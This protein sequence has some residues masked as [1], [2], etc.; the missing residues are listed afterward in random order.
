MTKQDYAVRA[1]RTETKF[2]SRDNLM[3]QLDV[4]VPADALEF[5]RAAHN[6]QDSKDVTFTVQVVNTKDGDYRTLKFTSKGSKMKDFVPVATL[7]KWCDAH[8]NLTA[9]FDRAAYELNLIV[10]VR[11]RKPDAEPLF[12]DDDQTT[13]PTPPE[14]V[15]AGVLNAPKE[16]LALPAGEDIQDAEFT[17]AP[18]EAEETPEQFVAR[19]NQAQLATLMESAGFDVTDWDDPKRDQEQDAAEWRELLLKNWVRVEGTGGWAMVKDQFAN[20]LPEIDPFEGEDV[21]FG[22]AQPVAPVTT[23][24]EAAEVMDMLEACS[25]DQLNRLLKAADVSVALM[26]AKVPSPAAQNMARIKLLKNWHKVEGTDAL[27]QVK[28]EL[29]QQN[30][31]EVA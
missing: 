21:P 16:V 22:P 31:G 4:Q 6:A 23:E 20:P 10:E 7:E 27:A 30:G 24:A 1:Y 25:S 29:A 3:S 28:A 14:T 9:L 11:E 2:D 8:D 19:C 15:V 26:R 13:Q 17:T 12:G 18:T 5:L